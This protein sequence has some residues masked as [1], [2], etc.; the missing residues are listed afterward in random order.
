[1]IS[2][3][4]LSLWPTAD[5]RRQGAA[6]VGQLS[7]GRLI[8]RL[9]PETLLT[10]KARPRYHFLAVYMQPTRKPRFDEAFCVFGKDAP[11]LPQRS[12][13]ST[14]RFC[15]SLVDTALVCARDVPVLAN[16]E[17]QPSTADRDPSS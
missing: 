7:M 8:R 17:T 10:Y 9:A 16:P 6:K 2:W 12:L 1:M 13:L 11:A 15:L 14:R 3:L 5:L 4:K